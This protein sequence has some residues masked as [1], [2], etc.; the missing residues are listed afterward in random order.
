MHVCLACYRGNPYCGGQGIYL[1]HL[2]RALAAE[3]VRV[4]V[5]SGPPYPD[6]MPWARVE[7]LENG[8]FWGR[9]PKEFFGDIAPGRV[10]R[11]L[12]FLEFAAT[13]TGYL[14][15]LAAFSFRAANLLRRLHRETPFDLIHDVETLGF[16]LLLARA[17]LNLPTVSTIHHP[18]RRDLEAS[19]TRAKTLKARYYSVVF[20]PLIMQA[21]VAR[22][23]DGLITSSKVG[24]EELQAAFGVREEKVHLVYTGVDTG[25]F[26]PGPWEKRE[27]DRILFVG[28]AEDRRKGI[29]YLLE[30]LVMLPP[31]VSLR[32]VDQ[33]YPH[34]RFAPAQVRDLGLEDRVTFTGRL[35]EAEL[36]EEYQQTR[37]LI[38][39][40]LFEGFGLPV[41]EAMACGTPVVTT[42]AGSLPEV[43]G[44]DEE[45]GLL[46]PPRNPRA[47]AEAIGRLLADD[48]LAQDLGRR[49]RRRAERLFSW[50]RTAENTIQVYQQLIARRASMRTDVRVKGTSPCLTIKTS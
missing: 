26:S 19:L 9:E 43:V 7:R 1:Y 11:P 33:G 6:P 12:N 29:R 28:N 45:G 22:R 49:A 24:V 17:G 38:L 41:A 25:T 40:S 47:L 13:R 21:L 5:L 23:I 32:I 48:A 2:S 18:L 39:P 8:L 35:T 34:K 20:Y 46:A 27:A 42:R 50:K 15:E 14:S 37:V 36:V 3:G 44:E 16:G 10:L 31:Q 4:T 30:A